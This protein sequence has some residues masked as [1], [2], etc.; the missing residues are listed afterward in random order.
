MSEDKKGL[1]RYSSNKMNFKA[2]RNVVQVEKA[3]KR[4][5]N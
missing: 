3:K 1:N 2:Y 4:R 5:P